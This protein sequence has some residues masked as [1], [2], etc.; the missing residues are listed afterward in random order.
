[1]PVPPFST[2]LH[3]RI[4]D[5]A[6]M[7]RALFCLVALG[8]LANA[9]PLRAQEPPEAELDFVRK[10][11]AKGYID[12]A[13]AYLEIMQKRNDP[14]LAGILPLEQA[15][16]ILAA[17]REKDAEQRFGLF[18]Q[19]RDFLKAYTEKN[20]GKPE[21]A[22]GTLELARLSSY[23]GQALL[24]KA[25]REL[26]PAVQQELAKPAETKFAL[27]AGELEAAI[28]LL[29]SLTEDANVSETL[30]KQLKQEL[31]QARFDKGIN[32]IDQARTYVNLAKEDLNLKRAQI[33]QEAKKVFDALRDEE[34]LDIRS[35]ANAWL[36]KIAMESQ[37]PKEVEKFYT[38]VMTPKGPEARAGQRWAR[39]FDMQDVLTN[40]QNPRSAKLK[41]AKDKLLL[42]EKMGKSWLSDYPTSVHTPV[43]EG[44]LWEL[45]NAYY[46]QAK[47]AEKEKKPKVTAE[48]HYTEAKKYYD[49]LAQGEGDYSEKANKA[50]LGISFQL[51][52]KRKDFRNFDEYYLKG[53]FELIEMQEIA[54]NRAKAQAS[55]DP[56]DTEKY[57]KQWKTKLKDVT[58]TFGRAIA[59]STD[60][61]PIQK[62]DEARYYLTSAYLLSGD[63]HRAAVAGEA[64]GRNRPPT[65]HSPAG[66]GYA[67]DAYGSLLDKEFTEGTKERLKGLIDYVLAP[68]AQKFWSTDP[69]T[70]VARYRLAMLYKKEGDAR[71]AIE[72]LERLP[73]EFPA[74]L[75][76][77]SQL[78]FIALTE[79][80]ENQNL[81]EKQKRELLD[82]VRKAVDR[83]PP[84][85]NDADPTTALLY[86]LAQL[87]KSKLLYTSA[88]RMLDSDEPLKAE[89]QFRDMGKF[90]GGL[91]DRF[92][93]M[94]IKL[95][96]KSRDMIDLELRVMRKYADLGIAEVE[97]REDKFDKVLEVT[98]PTVDAVKKLDKGMGPIRMKDYQV[99]G[100]ILGLSLRAQ[101][102]KGNIKDAKEALETVKRLADEE[103]AKAEG[104]RPSDRVVGNLLKDISA[105]VINLKKAKKESELKKVIESFSN[106]LE[107]LVQEKD[108]QKMP[109]DER[110]MLARAY[111][112][113]EQYKKAADLYKQM[114]P[115]KLL[116]SK[117]AL[118]D[119]NEAEIGELA[120][121]WTIKWEHVKALRAAKDYDEALKVVDAW[122]LHPKALFGIPQASM[123]RNFILEDKG[124]YGAATLEWNKLMK[125]IQNKVGQDPK[126]KKAYFE[127]Y[128]YGTRTLFKYGMHDPAVKSKDKVV[129]AAA[130]RIVDLEFSKTRDGWDTVGE[131]FIQ[132]LAAEPV[133]KESYERQKKKRV[134]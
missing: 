75:Y 117:K 70:G 90:V 24:T 28:K 86:F 72:E 69:V 8:C 37:D 130:K 9:A 106:F 74:Y 67:I 45:A 46:L 99:T 105:Q 26:D 79:R 129:D 134:Q 58:A 25:L 56:K 102:R 110:K 43:G 5:K 112:A 81:T 6:S 83:M 11:R 53:Q 87:E 68:E 7:K 123:E 80:K 66:A 51:M 18:N 15:R 120:E 52:G 71:R 131:M 127:A 114:P 44:V 48:A 116:E 40:A 27:A 36:M 78:V 62:L 42:V 50:S 119:F 91:T 104:S 30:K 107:T 19:A 94:P 1:M 96:P 132:L 92:E 73:R 126:M 89:Q 31:Q 121:Y 115:S 101:V 76:A 17:A 12:Q 14:K 125:S 33:V 95:T 100:D 113:L 84:L 34:A 64:L 60:R 111:S 118:K 38:R 20:A 41:T 3:S 57:E 32:Y 59:L 85:P 61:T 47:E 39:Y 103:D 35:Q 124:T 133:L 77:Q 97:Y 21:A 63:L 82:I 122:I 108:A 98:K 88:Y 29:Q 4:W 16:T 54:R 65:R 55:G 10:L 109:L 13:R 22:Q 23:E 128:F 93:K 2:E 49:M